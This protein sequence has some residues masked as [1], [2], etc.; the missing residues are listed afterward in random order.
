MITT[1]SAGAPAANETRQVAARHVY[2]AECALHAA[3][4]AGIDAWVSMASDRLH[5]ALV[6][7]LKMGAH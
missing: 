1:G 5:E 7:Y 3:H 2:D 6:E 4:Q